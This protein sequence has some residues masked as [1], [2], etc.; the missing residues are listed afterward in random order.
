MYSFLPHSEKVLPKLIGVVT[1]KVLLFPVAL[2]RNLSLSIYLL[3]Q[4]VFLAKK[5]MFVSDSSQSQQNRMG[6]EGAY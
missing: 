6:H 5:A 4:C 1:I 3:A 2:S